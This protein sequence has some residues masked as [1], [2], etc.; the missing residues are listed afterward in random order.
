MNICRVFQVISLAVAAITFAAAGAQADTTSFDVSLNTSALAG[1][2][3]LL[4]G[5]TDGDAV[6]D[7]TVTL[8]NFNFGTGSALGSPSISGTGI[9]GDLTSGI[10]LNDSGF[11]ALFSQQFDSGSS[12]S[13]LLNTTNAFTSGTP[14][15]FAMYVCN[16]DVSACYS[17]DASTGA[18]LVLNLTGSALTPGSFTLNGASDQ[19]LPA[20]VVTVAT[21]TGTGTGTGNSNVPEPSILLLVV[22]GLLGVAVLTGGKVAAR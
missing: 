1:P 16:S 18:V 9:S 22:C 19:D 8:S 4:F 5:I 12:L 15:A 20:P 21:G 3:T 13:F 7:N 14:D 17:D 10:S 6:A 2:Q 11:S